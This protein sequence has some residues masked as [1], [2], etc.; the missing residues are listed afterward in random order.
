[1]DAT[2]NHI[3]FP[4]I[5]RKM[6]RH[7]PEKIKLN[8]SYVLFTTPL[9]YEIC[10]WPLNLQSKVLCRVKG[11]GAATTEIAAT[12]IRWNILGQTA[13]QNPLAKLFNLRDPEIL[14]MPWK[15]ST[16]ISFHTFG[17]I[18]A[19]ITNSN[20]NE[21][22]SSKRARMG[23]T[24][25]KSDSPLQLRVFT[26]FD[27]SWPKGFVWR[28]V[29]G[30]SQIILLPNLSRSLNFSIWEFRS[31]SVSTHRYIFRAES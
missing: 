24:C 17:H 28:A 18:E 16:I 8:M 15:S 13:N 5:P 1:M 11:W 3:P 2:I 23:F 4:Y 14:Q 26:G 12:S 10:I 19:T 20:R 31:I 6:S 21:I 7:A 25:I 9:K 22:P 29:P 30:K 27:Y